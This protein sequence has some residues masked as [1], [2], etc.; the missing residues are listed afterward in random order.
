MLRF[1][2]GWLSSFFATLEAG[3]TGR[4]ELVLELLD[5]SGSINELEFASE[6]R[7]A[8]AANINFQLRH[9]AACCERIATAALDRGDHVVGMNVFFHITNPS[10][11]SSTTTRGPFLLYRAESDPNFNY[12]NHKFYT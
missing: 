8:R 9:S 5:A 2:G 6:K 12:E 10:N 3:K 1:S 11:F 7:M 4:G